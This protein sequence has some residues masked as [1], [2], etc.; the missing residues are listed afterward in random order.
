MSTATASVAPHVRSESL[1]HLTFARVLRSEWIKLR[2]LRSTFWTFAIVLVVG[3]GLSALVA[4]AVPATRIPAAEH[5]A[6]VARTTSFGVSLGQLAVAVL[7]VLA[8]SGEYSTGMI[9][10]SFAAVPRRLPV[11]LAK[12][13]TLFASSFVVG[14]VTV[15]ISWAIAAPVLSG[16]GITA[17][18]FSSDTMWAIAGAGVY[19]GCV[20]V[21][22]L[23]LGTL[24]R[25]GAG[26][27]AAALGAV[28]LL[29]IIVGLVFRLTN[30]DWIGKAN[31]YLIS[32]AGAAMAGG[33][34]GDFE[35]WQNVL[36]VAVWTVVSLVA[37]AFVLM[38]R[39]A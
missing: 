33:T 19:L 31:D 3:I 14:A 27:I 2:S 32:N 11:L 22:G 17:T 16:K 10:S 7:G 5:A 15:A 34:N 23:G 24:I 13:I 1:G 25:S 38:R 35:P 36:V 12:A 21:F 37:G 29:P 28:F 8:I 9:R 6:F 39:D 4:F 30:I 26:G 20:A 18:F